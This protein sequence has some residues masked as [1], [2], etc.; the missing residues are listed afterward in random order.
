MYKAPQ[1][2]YYIVFLQL[3]NENLLFLERMIENIL[4]RTENLIFF[5]QTTKKTNIISWAD[6]KKQ[7]FLSRHQKKTNIF[8]ADDKNLNISWA[9]QRKPTISRAAGLVSAQT[10]GL[11]MDAR[12]PKLSFNR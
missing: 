10:Q 9:D 1:T 3:T 7:K 2:T 8:E 4:F 5:E 6:D 11:T 12:I